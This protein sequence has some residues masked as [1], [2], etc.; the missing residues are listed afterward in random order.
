MNWGRHMF[1]RRQW[2]PTRVLL[3]G[4][5]HGRRSRVGYSPWG[6]SESDTTERLHF[7]FSLSC[8]GKGN[9]NPLQCSCLE[10]LRNGG[11][12]WAAVYGV[13]QSRTWL[14]WLSS[15]RHV[16]RASQVALM[17]KNYPTNA[18]N[19]RY[20]SLIP[21]LGRPPGGGRGNPLQD[22]CLE[23]PM[24]GGV[25]QAIV[26]RVTHDWSNLACTYRHI[27]IKYIIRLK[28]TFYIISPKT[29]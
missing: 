28:T 9:G 17:V 8:I 2:H 13:A 19:I 26:H 14:K 16:F 1:Q 21:C 20:T 18:G 11:A 22:S 5:S 23:N 6:R 7:H 25:W 4:K 12:W 10:N 27:F 3:P 15:S 29:T 24:D